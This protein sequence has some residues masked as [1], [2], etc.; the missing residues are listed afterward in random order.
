MAFCDSMAVK[1]DSACPDIYCLLLQGN[2]KKKKEKRETLLDPLI[3]RLLFETGNNKVL[4]SILL[5]VF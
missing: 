5:C 1:L 4:L 2:R 3:L